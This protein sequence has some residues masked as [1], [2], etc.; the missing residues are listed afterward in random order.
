MY[1]EWNVVHT[2]FLGTYAFK[3]SLWVGYDDKVDVA[4]KVCE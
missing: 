3:G 2:D 4:I 1:E